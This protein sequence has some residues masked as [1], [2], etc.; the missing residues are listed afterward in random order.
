MNS[1]IAEFETKDKKKVEIHKIKE[2]IC[3][4]EGEQLKQ[5]NMT[6]YDCIRY[7]AHRLQGK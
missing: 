7:L 6:A 3:V 5:N 2:I 4:F 1:I